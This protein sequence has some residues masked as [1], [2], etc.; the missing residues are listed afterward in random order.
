[1]FHMHLRSMCI[2]LL[3]GRIF[4]RCLLKSSWFIVL[5]KHSIYFS[6]RWDLEPFQI[7]VP[8]EKCKR[9]N[10]K[11]PSRE[12]YSN[13]WEAEFP[14][15]WH[16]YSPG[17]QYNREATTSDKTSRQ[18]P[19]A[20][21][22]WPSAHGQVNTSAAGASPLLRCA[23]ECLLLS[24]RWQVYGDESSQGPSRTGPWGRG[25]KPQWHRDDLGCAG[26]L[27]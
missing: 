8:A 12:G 19:R 6:H 2:L 11:E 17:D 1:M 27:Q 20:V 23:R 7:T 18:C 4:Y 5:F 10:C 24:D 21:G 16:N 9:E 13:H 3:Y 14:P 22:K 15:I 26:S 25:D